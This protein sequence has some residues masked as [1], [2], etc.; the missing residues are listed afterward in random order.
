MR[1]W[2]RLKSAASKAP[3]PPLSRFPD[4]SVRLATRLGIAA[5]VFVAGVILVSRI[6]DE[7]RS[8]IDRTRAEQRKPIVGRLD[9]EQR[10][11]TRPSPRPAPKKPDRTDASRPPRSSQADVSKSPI[12]VTTTQASE[13]SDGNSGA[14]D[15]GTTSGGAPGDGTDAARPVA[16]PGGSGGGPGT[17]DGEVVSGNGGSGDGPGGDGGSN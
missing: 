7:D 5:V 9:D 3:E 2:M 1:G 6:S 13:T 12:I 10:H 11:P 8:P 15:T 4:E 14:A 16:G 17:G